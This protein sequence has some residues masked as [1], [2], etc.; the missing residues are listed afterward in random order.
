MYPV[1]CY[2]VCTFNQ[3]H[4]SLRCAAC[5]SRYSVVVLF[6]LYIYTSIDI[7]DA[8]VLITLD[9]VSIH[10]PQTEYPESIQQNTLMQFFQ[11]TIYIPSSTT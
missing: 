2:S 5:D 7:T 6:C 4:L 8:S 11:A 10:T 1:I 3:E 9:S